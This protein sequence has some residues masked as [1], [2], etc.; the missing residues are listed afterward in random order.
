MFIE[1]SNDNHFIIEIENYAICDH[2]QKFQV[3]NSLSDVST[4]CHWKI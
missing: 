2:N 1:I 4:H 3:F